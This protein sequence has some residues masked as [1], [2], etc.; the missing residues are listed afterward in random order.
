[1]KRFGLTVCAAFLFI[2]SNC[3]QLH[4]F[5]DVSVQVLLNDS[6]ITPRS[7]QAVKGETLHIEVVNQGQRAHNFVIPEMYIFTQNLAP[8]ELTNVSFVP[9]KLGRFNYYSDTGGKPEPGLSGFLTVS[10]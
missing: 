9:D 10:P 3:V 5:A 8:G 6:G 4:V 1:M 2:V 7:I